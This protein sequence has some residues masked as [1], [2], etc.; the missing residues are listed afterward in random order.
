[1]TKYNKSIATRLSYSQ[2]QKVMKD[3]KLLNT[4]NI[5]VLRAIVIE[6]LKNGGFS[7]E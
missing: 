6:H 5:G 3:K 4:T 2:Y 7:N 1:M